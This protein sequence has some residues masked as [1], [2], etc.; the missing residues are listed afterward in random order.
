M[1]L[2]FLELKLGLP[3][4]AV[5]RCRTFLEERS[6]SPKLAVE[7]V[8]YEYGKKLDG[9]KIAKDRVSS[10]AE[11]TD[12]KMIKG[13]CHSLLD[14]DRDAIKLFRTEAEKRF[15]KIDQCLRWPVIARHEEELRSIREEL[16]KAKRGLNDLPTT[17]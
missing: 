5:K 15:S 2:S 11:A 16:L 6:F 9:A 10:V 12:D 4:K 8:N 14:Q 3:A 1:E 7:I 17:A 13:V